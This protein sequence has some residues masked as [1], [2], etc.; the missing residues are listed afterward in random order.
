MAK[1]KCEHFI[2]QHS[3]SHLM[4]VEE[5]TDGTVRGLLAH[6]L[7][8]IPLCLRVEGTTLPKPGQRLRPLLLLLLLKLCVHVHVYQ[9]G[10][11]I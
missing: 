9:H 10:D 5:Q 3:S 8:V 2:K 1:D 4:C 6:A 7:V 11:G